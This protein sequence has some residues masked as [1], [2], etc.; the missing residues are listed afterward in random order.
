MR[1]F[2][3][4]VECPPPG[5]QE[6]QDA[7]W[8]DSESLTGPTPFNTGDESYV[9]K[10]NPS[11]TNFTSSDEEST[12]NRLEF[13][14]T[15]NSIDSLIGLQKS[16]SSDSSFDV[17]FEYSSQPLSSSD[18]KPANQTENS[19]QSCSK[20][21]I[22]ARGNS[23]A[24]FRKP[25]RAEGKRRRRDVHKVPTCRISDTKMFLFIQMQLCRK[26]SLREWLRAHVSHRDTLQVLYMFNEIVRAVEYVHLQV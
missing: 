5:W 7:A 11:E 23:L 3:A 10:M 9:S 26:E 20:T 21:N 13:P 25:S 2:H 16:Y 17:V 18:S 6:S 4:W 8:I 19:N 24:I 12:A 14:K 22:S 15:S 1:Y